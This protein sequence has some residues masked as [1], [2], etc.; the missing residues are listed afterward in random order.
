MARYPK[1]ARIEATAA[2]S[3]F[4]G[5]APA[6]GVGHCVARQFFSCGFDQ[7]TLAAIFAVGPPFG[8]APD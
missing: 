8:F 2:L 5:V 6:V 3:H 4:S 1:R 7:A